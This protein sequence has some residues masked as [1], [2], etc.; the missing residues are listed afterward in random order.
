MTAGAHPSTSL[1][2]TDLAPAL[3]WFARNG[4]TPLDFQ[5]E[6]W[7]AYLRGESGLVHAATGTGKTL[8]A[9]WGPLLEWIA[10]TRY[11][12]A[13]RAPTRR[14]VQIPRLRSE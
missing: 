5:R 2:M 6:V 10:E 3:E 12:A 9:W 4:W 7:T 13:T 8:A 14:T 11:S 1:G